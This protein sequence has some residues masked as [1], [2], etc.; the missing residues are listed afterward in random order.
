MKMDRKSTARYLL[1]LVCLVIFTQGQVLPVAMSQELIEPI[2]KANLISA[3]KLNRREKSPL[4]K[5]TVA[6]YIRLINRYGV[7]FPLT[8]ETEQEIRRAGEYFGNLD[9][10]KLL[11]AINNN[12]RPDEPTEAEMKEALL[13]VMEAQGG[14]RTA[15]GVM[16]ISNIIAGVSIK[17]SNFEK[18]GCAPPNYGPGYFCSY[19]VNVSMTFLSKGGGE[20]AERQMDSF[21]FLIQWL[22]GGNG[23]MTERVTKK[24]VWSKNRWVISNEQTGGN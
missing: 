18:L 14:K 19:N 8:T 17:M 1:P 16:E 21:N 2:S 24:F 9:L 11:T 6:G 7:E 23:I 10:D 13:T 15:D 5:M 20:R 4:K 3:I 22:M 12:Y